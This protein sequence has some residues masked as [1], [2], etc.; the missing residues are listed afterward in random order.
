[1]VAEQVFKESKIH[2]QGNPSG[3]NPR[4][5]IERKRL[6]LLTSGL[7]GL[8]WAVLVGLVFMFNSGE[9]DFWFPGRVLAYVLLVI[10]PT[11]TFV[12]I[13]R[14]LGFSLYGYWAVASWALFGF[15]LAF[16]PSQP[17]RGWQENL[18]PLGLFLFA[19]F[20][21][22]LSVGLPVFYRLGF[23]LFSRRIEQHDIGRAWREAILAG[24]AVL[25][26]SVLSIL[27]ALTLL[28]AVALLLAF[29]VLELLLL[30]RNI[31]RQ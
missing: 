27:D 14:A 18:T 3:R 31:G 19:L 24:L 5:K 26:L 11:L 10:A 2:Q 8:A 21:V 6:L 1:M 15:M 17:E 9:Y 25:L 20:M 30:S 29:V 13:G 12:P 28:S 7:A 22:T 16:V 23:R 4:S